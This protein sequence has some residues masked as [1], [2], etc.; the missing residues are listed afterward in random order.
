MIMAGFSVANMVQHLVV[1]PLLHNY[2]MRPSLA[3]ITFTFYACFNVVYVLATA[4]VIDVS[5]LVPE[6]K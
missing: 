3:A 4:G 1:V 6:T 5:F 2:T